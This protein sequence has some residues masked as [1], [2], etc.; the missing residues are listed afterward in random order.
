MPKLNHVLSNQP[1]F[2]PSQRSLSPSATISTRRRP[3]RHAH[4]LVSRPTDRGRPISASIRFF[5]RTAHDIEVGFLNLVFLDH[6]RRGGERALA[7][8][9]A[10]SFV[11]G[12]DLLAV[13]HPVGSG[14]ADLDVLSDAGSAWTA[15]DRPRIASRTS[16]GP[17]CSELLKVRYSGPWLGRVEEPEQCRKQRYSA[18][19]RTY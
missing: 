18:A 5:R 2:R 11:L 7:G 15:S 1:S 13:S 4:Q 16:L 3:S 19:S 6:A 17:A 9:V 8:V 14:E 12:R 10:R